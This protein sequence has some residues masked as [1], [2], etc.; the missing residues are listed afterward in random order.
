MRTF[1]AIA[2]AAIAIATAFPAAAAEPMRRMNYFDSKA[3]TPQEAALLGEWRKAFKPEAPRGVMYQAFAIGDT[4]VTVVIGQQD[5]CD[6]GPQTPTSTQTWAT[7]PLNIISRGPKGTK[8]QTIED[9]CFLHPNRTLQPD[10]P[11]PETNYSATGYDPVTKVI[12]V[13]TY[14]DGVEIPSCTKSL[15]VQ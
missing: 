15:A 8:V 9:G 2:S 7:C 13:K 5:S 1:L 4:T 6:G 10:D 3:P 12:S 14:Q 11:N